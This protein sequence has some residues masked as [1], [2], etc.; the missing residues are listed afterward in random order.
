MK[1]ACDPYFNLVRRTESEG[2]WSDEPRV[3]CCVA[4][5][6]PASCVSVGLSAF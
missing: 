3:E 1:H 5:A 2:R 4:D 6:S